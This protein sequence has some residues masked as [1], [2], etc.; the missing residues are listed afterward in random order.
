MAGSWLGLGW[1][2]AWFGLGLAGSGGRRFGLAL[3]WLGFGL[4]GFGLGLVGLG[5]AWFGLGLALGW[6]WLGL[7]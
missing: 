1:P 4:V 2:A 3:V 6:H 7:G 5:L